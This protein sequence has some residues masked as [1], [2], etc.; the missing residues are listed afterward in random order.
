MMVCLI[1][2]T[3]I[4]INRKNWSTTIKLHLKIPAFIFKKANVHKF[5]SEYKAPQILETVIWR[6]SVEKVF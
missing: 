6:C 2:H 1:F 5:R 4:I 3:A